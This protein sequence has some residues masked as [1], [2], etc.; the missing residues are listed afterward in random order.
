[1][2][3]KNE[4]NGQCEGFASCAKTDSVATGFCA[5]EKA[6]HHGIK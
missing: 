2:G 4:G 5:E 3:V 6:R 1:M